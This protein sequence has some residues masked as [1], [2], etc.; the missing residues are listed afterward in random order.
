LDFFKRL[1][2]AEFWEIQSPKSETLLNVRSRN[3]RN[4]NISVFDELLL[5]FSLFSDGILT[6]FLYKTDDDDFFVTLAVL[7]AFII[8]EVKR[9]DIKSGRLILYVI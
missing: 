5:I 9:E 7:N 2:S 3:C 1:N 6:R 8:I 4:K